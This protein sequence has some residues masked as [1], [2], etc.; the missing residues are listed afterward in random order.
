MGGRD[1]NCEIC[2]RFSAT[3]PRSSVGGREWMLTRFARRTDGE[4]QFFFS[5]ASPLIIPGPEPIRLCLSPHLV[6]SM[7]QHSH[8][9]RADRSSAFGLNKLSLHV[10][11]CARLQVIVFSANR[12]CDRAVHDT[13]A[14]S[15]ELVMRI[16]TFSSCEDSFFFF[17]RFPFDLIR[18]ATTG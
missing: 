18:S 3:E 14:R 6:I 16:C 7:V 10:I 1:E 5:P 4:K 8:S 9:L 12:I 11:Y 15:R 2:S 13:G 17:F